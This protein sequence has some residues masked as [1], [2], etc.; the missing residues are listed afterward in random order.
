[1]LLNELHIRALIY[2]KLKEARQKSVR[3]DLSRRGKGS[4]STEGNYEGPL[5]TISNGKKYL[6]DPLIGISP[7]GYWENFRKKLNSHIDKE[8]PELGIEIA[9]LGVTRSLGAAAD[10]GT[11]TARIAGSKHG[12][13]LAQDVR[14]HTKKYG[15]FTAYK[16][17]NPKLAKDQKLVDAIISF[18]NTP[19]NKGKV[20]WGGAF[21]SGKKSLNIGEQ[22]KDRGVLEFHHFEFASGDMPKYFEQFKDEL[23]KFSLKS[24]DMNSS[25]GLAKLYKAV[26]TAQVS[27]KRRFFKKRK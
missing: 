15:K 7:P 22:P 6:G 2:E 26:L 25:K 5:V 20:Y 23:A 18:L 27:N 21:S 16:K 1:M 3:A 13:G 10:P 24:S 12:A 8:Y 11:N 9:N 17:D 14:M 19:E 4:Q